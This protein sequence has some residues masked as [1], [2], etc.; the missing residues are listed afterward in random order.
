MNPFYITLYS[1]ASKNIYPH[2]HGGDFTVE[3][4]NTLDL[5][6]A[7]EVALVEVSYFGQ[8][9][10]NIPTEY[11]RVTVS[12]P[13]R[14]A[15]PTR[16][17]LNYGKIKVMYMEVWIT[18]WKPLEGNDVD[19]R[20]QF[21]SAW[22]LVDT[23]TFENKHY[24]WQIFKEAIANLKMTWQK[25]LPYGIR[26]VSVAVTERNT[27]VFTA[28]ISTGILKVVFSK[29]LFDLLQLDKREVSYSDQI[30]DI[31]SFDHVTFTIPLP[32]KDE[33]PLLFTP[34][35]D[36]EI[37]FAIDDYKVEIPKMFLT[38]KQFG[39]CL[40]IPDYKIEFNYK[41]NEWVMEVTYLRETEK[42]GR[43]L[44]LSEPV[45]KSLCQVGFAYFPALPHRAVDFRISDAKTAPESDDFNPNFE[46]TFQLSHN[47]FPTNKSLVE[48]LNKLTIK[49]F[50][51]M[52][53]LVFN[54]RALGRVFSYDEVKNTC[55]FE[56]DSE[57]GIQLTSFLLNILGLKNTSESQKGTSI[58]LIAAVRPFLHVYCNIILPQYVNDNEYPLLRVINNN[59]IADEKTMITF[60]QPHYYPVS[61]RY[62][63]NINIYIADYTNFDP[64]V[65][66]HPI[67]LLL[68]FR[69]RR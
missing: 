49:H 63:S 53:D 69:P 22:T 11:G 5:A 54:E 17:I 15:Q 37:W 7:W 60:H 4:H 12:V 66:T 38:I 44:K 65:F 41:E 9:F 52:G 32:K 43:S 26:K 21:D 48:E 28:D 14:K 20:L 6:G 2:N 57:Y 39:E 62:I 58:R 27:I 56:V 10:S 42:Y 23:L 46:I 55:T 51:K 64:L 16:L 35:T 18:Q 30:H 59:A 45:Q 47:F 1:D 31:V 36:G 34:R 25:R 24:T 67:I 61:Q 33:S 13:K 50:Y 29:D 8:Y 40:T 3:L 19:G 68:H